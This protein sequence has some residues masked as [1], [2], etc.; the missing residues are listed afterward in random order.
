MRLVKRK[1]PRPD[2]S[3]QETFFVKEENRVINSLPLTFWS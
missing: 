3:G 1:I 2:K